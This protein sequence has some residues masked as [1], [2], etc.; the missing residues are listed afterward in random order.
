[1]RGLN[2]EKIIKWFV[3]YFSYV[4]II[5]TAIF[6]YIA[7]I[8]TNTGFFLV[9][10]SFLFGITFVIPVLSYL[11]IKNITIS[12]NLYPLY[13]SGESLSISYT[14]KNSGSYPAFFILIK[15]EI[16]NYCSEKEIFTGELKILPPKSE[17]TINVE[18]IAKKR[19]I[20]ELNKISIQSYF[21]FTFYFYERNFNTKDKI[22][23]LP[24]QPIY[25]QIPYLSRYQSDKSSKFKSMTAESE[26]VGLREHVPSDGLRL[27]HW[28]KS[29]AKGKLLVKEFSSERMNKTAVMIDGDKYALL[30]KDEEIPFEDMITASAG[31]IGYCSRTKIKSYIISKQNLKN[32]TGDE[33]LQIL[34]GLQPEEISDILPIKNIKK[35]GISTLFLFTANP[36]KIDKISKICFKERIN[37]VISLFNASSYK[38]MKK[39]EYES[40]TQEIK[41]NKEQFFMYSK[42]QNMK[43]LF[44]K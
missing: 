10:S 18:F 22:T 19:G 17:K 43:L 29:A 34:A 23:I 36:Q 37:L 42:D 30:G 4:S 31:I 38:K 7:S 25:K 16:K 11:N 3:R 35:N 6:L 8:L 20:H 24:T 40:Y 15:D 5:L 1:M 12:R 9:I 27:V 41:E 32:G 21:P 26:F 13:T 28:Q 39:S 2:L 33:L 44:T 14:L